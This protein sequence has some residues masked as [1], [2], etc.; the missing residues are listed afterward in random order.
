ML[1]Q[2]WSIPITLLLCWGNW[3]R[4]QL[5]AAHT[6]G[7]GGFIAHIAGDAWRR[8]GCTWT[9]STAGT[10]CDPSDRFRGPEKSCGTWERGRHFCGALTG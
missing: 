3:G 6:E 9:I 1:S 8:A 7:L 10:L 5:R 2:G 4:D